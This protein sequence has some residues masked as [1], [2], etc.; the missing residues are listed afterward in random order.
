MALE[1][2]IFLRFCFKCWTVSGAVEYQG[3]GSI[4]STREETPNVCDDCYKKMVAERGEHEA[5]IRIT[6]ARKNLKKSIWG[7]K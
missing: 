3:R 2:G 6:Q 4:F 7:E 1:K 5:R